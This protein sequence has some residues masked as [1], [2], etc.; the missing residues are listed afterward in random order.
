MTK[1]LKE[2]FKCLI[3][4]IGNLRFSSQAKTAFWLLKTIYKYDSFEKAGGS[5]IRKVVKRN[6][7][8]GFK[9]TS[10]E[11][12]E[13]YKSSHREKK[14]ELATKKNPTPFPELPNLERNEIKRIARNFSRD[15]AIAFDGFEDH[16]F[17]IH[18]KCSEAN[19]QD[20]CKECKQKIYFISEIWS[21]SYWSDKQSKKHMISRLIPLNKIHPKTPETH[22]YRPI[23]VTS[24]IVKMLESYVHKKLAT[25][26]KENI[27]KQQIGFA[28]GCSIHTNLFRLGNEIYKNQRKR[29]GRK[30]IHMLFVDLKSAFDSVHR[31]TLYK[32]LE[33]RNILTN[34]EISLIKFIHENLKVELNGENCL[35][36]KGVPQGSKISPLLFNIYLN[37]LIEELEETLLDS[38]KSKIFAYADDLLVTTY[39]QSDTKNAI[40]KIESWC[41]RY[42]MKMNKKKSGILLLNKKKEEP[43]PEPLNGIPYVETYKYLGVVMNSQFTIK[44]HIKKLEK[45]INFICCKLYYV[46]K[47]NSIKFR[48]NSFNVFIAPLFSQM[49]GLI[50]FMNKSE[51]TK[52]LGLWKLTLKRM[53]GLNRNV[54]NTIFNKFVPYN[55]IKKILEDKSKY[56][57]QINERFQEEFDERIETTQ[58]IFNIDH[59]QTF[60]RINKKAN[61]FI[62]TLLKT[63]GK[64]IRRRKRLKSGHLEEYFN[65]ELEKIVETSLTDPDEPNIK[66]RLNVL[67]ASLEEDGQKG[68]FDELKIGS[69]ERIRRALSISSQEALDTGA[70]NRRTTQRT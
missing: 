69:L 25:Y 10:K 23:V 51:K 38:A 17:R 24:P 7:T 66:E 32:L 11:I 14:Q 26:C 3:T 22:Q 33:T 30:K 65:M 28:Q 42:K 58:D 53:I 31:E 70:I 16:L 52:Y 29:K 67:K 9:E 37:T 6:K 46:F 15:K 68:L 57:E 21:K 12:I 8:L 1:L 4:S 62:I 39:S 63:I 34:P 59:E 60:T 54:K 5:I 64:K 45:K 49:N 43:L 47:K 56:K 35:T 40:Q 2:N 27:K 20:E 50:Y 36:S 13:H 44:D 61:C 41:S 55:P 18:P 48:I 19:E